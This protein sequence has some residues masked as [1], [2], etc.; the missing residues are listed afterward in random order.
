MLGKAPVSES[1]NRRRSG[2]LLGRSSSPSSSN[3]GSRGPKQGAPT[4]GA[5]QP[6]LGK[7]GKPRGRSDF[8]RG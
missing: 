8:R 3:G 5:R 1:E 7:S 4:F 6:R 2:Q